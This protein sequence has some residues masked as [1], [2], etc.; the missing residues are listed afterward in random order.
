VGPF[1][2]SFEEKIYEKETG[3]KLRGR[4]VF[5]GAAL[6]PAQLSKFVVEKKKKYKNPFCNQR[7]RIVSLK[8][9]PNSPITSKTEGLVTNSFDGK[10]N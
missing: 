3:M 10:I 5:I 9:Y 1:A 4:K 2:G 6:L 8:Y 7:N